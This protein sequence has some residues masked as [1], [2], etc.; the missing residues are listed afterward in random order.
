MAA[1]LSE[2]WLAQAT[3]RTSALPPTSYG[4][5]ARIQF[6]AEGDGAGWGLLITGGRVEAWVP[7]HIEDADI[8]VRCPAE[9]APALL[10]AGSG[11]DVTARTTVAMERTSGPYVGP[12]PPLDFLANAAR[13]SVLP[14]VHL[15]WHIS[16]TR[17]PFGAVE[18][19]MV[20]EDGRLV[21]LPLGPLG[22][23]DVVLEC[24]FLHAMLMRRGEITMLDALRYGRISGNEG[25][26][27]LLAG[28][29][30]TPTYVELMRENGS[31]RGILAL[32]ALG[33]VAGQVDYRRTMAELTGAG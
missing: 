6:V 17:G 11:T 4:G 27:G 16:L 25:A 32:C 9:L 33:E 28:L 15:R 5:D 13:L 2:A 7:G 31:G 3:E 14:D 21:D 23:A 19:G 8:E 29:L 22:D 1:F 18:Y 30:E 24:P 26:L 12:P 10:A 20:F